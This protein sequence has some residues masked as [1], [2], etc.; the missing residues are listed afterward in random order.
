MAD[1]LIRLAEIEVAVVVTPLRRDAEVPNR[2][3]VVTH[4]RGDVTEAVEHFGN[5]PDQQLLQPVA[6]FGVAAVAG[7]AIALAFQGTFSNF[8]AGTMLLVFRPIRPGDFVEV[9][10]VAAISNEEAE[11][12]GK[13][14]GVER[15]TADYMELIEKV[16][17]YRTILGSTLRRL[18]ADPRWQTWVAAAPDRAAGQE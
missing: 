3:R 4:G 18:G 10:G 9:A 11:S 15:T 13:A 12:F 2:Q 8:A 5:D 1:A 7:L 17:L 14:M 6:T 16:K